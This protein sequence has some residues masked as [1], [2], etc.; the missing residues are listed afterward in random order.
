[1]PAI[2]AMLIILP[3]ITSFSFFSISVMARFEQRKAPNTIFY[4]MNTAAANTVVHNP[5]LFPSADWQILEVL[6]I[7]PLALYI[8][9]LSSHALFISNSIPRVVASIVA[10]R[11]SAYSQM[12]HQ[13]FSTQERISIIITYLQY[14]VKAR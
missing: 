5:S 7:W 8:Y 11:S 13:L 10:A 3:F 14:E 6:N 4:S 2:E 12:R 9:F 1:M